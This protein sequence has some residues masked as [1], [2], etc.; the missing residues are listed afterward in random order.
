MQLPRSVLPSQRYHPVSDYTYESHHEGVPLGRL[1]L[2][3]SNG[4]VQTH[5]LAAPS[6][7]CYSQ[8]SLSPPIHSI[9]TPP[10]LPTQ[11]LTS[12]YGTSLRGERSLH[13]HVSLQEL[14]IRNARVRK[15]PIYH[16][17]SFADY[18]NKVMQKELDKEQPVWPD[19]LEDAFLDGTYIH[20][21]L[22]LTE[23]IANP[24]P[25]AAIDPA[26]G[27]KEILFEDYPIRPKHAHYR[28]SMDLSLDTSSS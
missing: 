6:T 22:P 12:S 18:R 13:R 17:K 24:R 11:A 20:S 25:S 21:V 23:A 15:N 16:H 14:P 9:P 8:L 4:N 27:S 1:P 2:S 7:L 19:W 10:I 28:I 3:E 26:D 5:S